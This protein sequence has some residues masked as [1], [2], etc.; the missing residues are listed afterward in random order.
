MARGVN[1]KSLLSRRGSLLDNAPSFLVR[2]KATN[3]VP[4]AGPDDAADE[5]PFDQEFENSWTATPVTP[6]PRT[7]TSPMQSGKQTLQAAQITEVEWLVQQAALST[8][9]TFQ[10]FAYS[11]SLLFHPRELTYY[12]VM[13]HEGDVW[14]VLKAHDLDAAEPAFRHFVEQAMRLADAEM[15]RAYIE[16]QTEQSSRLIAESESQIERARIELQRGS[17]QDQKV[18]LQQREIRKELAQLEAR[19]V[20]SQAQLNK[21]QRELHQ[22]KATAGESVPHL[23]TTR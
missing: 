3:D 12:A 18:A 5:L 21:L 10:S 15:R 22:L 23:P 17:A 11:A 6:L 19:R 2:Q 8:F 14:R 4:L 20:A 7:T 16:A 13:Y 9:R 1:V